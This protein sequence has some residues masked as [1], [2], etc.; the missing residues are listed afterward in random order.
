MSHHVA[1]LNIGRFKAPLDHPTMKEFTDFLDPVNKLA[2]GS[3]GFVW[4]LIDD[5][6]RSSSYVDNPFEQEDMIVNFSIWEDVDSLKHFTYNTVH[7][8]FVKHRNR[9]FHRMESHHLVLWWVREGVIP[10]L[11]EA[12]TRLEMLD[13]NGPTPKAFTLARVF[14]PA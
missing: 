13:A 7:A 12:K 4:R 2:E 9:W 3:P 8:Y 6:G 5:S 1:Q 14:P 10:G 11:E